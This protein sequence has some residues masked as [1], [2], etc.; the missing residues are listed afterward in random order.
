[1]EALVSVLKCLSDYTRFRILHIIL[2]HDQCVGSL[3]NRNGISEPSVSQHL[4]IL[5]KSDMVRGEKRGY[6]THYSVK[7]EALCQIG[8]R[9]IQISKTTC[10]HDK[11]CF[12]VSVRE[13]N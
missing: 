10:S 6:W 8:E 3:A 1:M 13:N 4:Q 11:S 12:E 7:R 2:T 9:L 5:R